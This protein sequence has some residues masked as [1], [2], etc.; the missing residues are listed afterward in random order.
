MFL[1]DFAGERKKYSL[2]SIDITKV[3]GHET[4]ILILDIPLNFTD[5]IFT[6]LRIPRNTH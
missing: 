3:P 6:I 2:S 4:V 1:I 5:T